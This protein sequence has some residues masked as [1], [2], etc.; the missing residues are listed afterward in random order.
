MKLSSFKGKIYILSELEEDTVGEEWTSSR[1]YPLMD[2]DIHCPS[3][4]EI[5]YGQ[6]K[7]LAL[8]HS[9]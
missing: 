9:P 5:E 7:G 6:S 8:Y 4:H 3:Y 1:E 2:T